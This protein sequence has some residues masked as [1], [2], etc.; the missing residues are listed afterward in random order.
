MQHTK[1]NEPKLLLLIAYCKYIEI[2]NETN[3]FS[4]L[5]FVS[6]FFLKRFDNDRFFPAYLDQFAAGENVQVA[7]DI[8]GWWRLLTTLLQAYKL[9]YEALSWSKSYHLSQ[10]NFDKALSQGRVVIE[11]AFGMLKGSGFIS[12]SNLT[13]W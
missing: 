1:L 13:N 6:N 2:M 7:G 8:A 11:Q 4:F 12:Q 3:Q 10:W 5:F 9:V